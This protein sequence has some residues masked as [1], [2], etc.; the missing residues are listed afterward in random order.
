MKDIND[1][2]RDRKAAADAM[3]SAADTMATLEGV[4]GDIDQTALDAAQADFDTAQAAFEAAGRLVARAETVEAAQTVAAISETQ[5]PP[6]GN[7]APSG[8]PIAG[9]FTNPDHK[10]ADIGLMV[11]SLLNNKGDLTRS[12]AQLESDGHTGISAA[13]SGATEGA[14][15]VTIPRAAANT[16]IELLTPRVVVRSMGAV[17]HDMPAGELRNAR[18]ASGP[19]A[20]YGPENGPAVESEPT[21][22]KVDEK[23][24]T[25]K[26]L[27]PVGNALLRH[28]NLSVGLAVRDLMVEFMGLREDLAFLRGDGSNDT[29]VGLL[30]FC[31][32]ANKLAG[33]AN[34]ALVVEQNLRKLVS[35]VEDANVAMLKPGWIM[36]A[37]TKNFLANVRD[38]DSGAKIFPSIETNGTLMGYPIGKTSQVPNNLGA[39]SNET[40]VSFVDF[41]EIMI[42]DSQV[43]T[44]ATST[45]A[46]YVDQGGVTRSAFQDDKTLMRAIAEHDMAPRHDEAIAMLNGVSWGL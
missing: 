22:D 4:E 29:P 39:G 31:P 9:A 13:L 2:R 11:S 19:T 34:T 35:L 41:A 45:E 24:K 46:A 33:I 36:R 1:Y 17:I 42:G 5:N 15:G 20:S 25:L 12:V 23:F 8:S 3:K 7:P 27:V 32:V 16:I 21:F 26:S 43:I 30:N 37:S 44:V 6:I 38:P 18:I 14:G 28:S 40:E 10:G